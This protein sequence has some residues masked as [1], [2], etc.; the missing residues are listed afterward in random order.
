MERQVLEK[1]KLTPIPLI[2][3]T[4]ECVIKL[5]G[6]SWQRFKQLDACLDGIKFLRLT[7]VTGLLE[8]M[9][10]SSKHERLK[11]TIGY[12]LE[13]Y[14]RENGIRFYGCGGFTLMKEGESSGEPDESYCIGKDKDIPDIVIEVIITSGSIK[15]LD[16]YKSKNVPEVWFW[17]SEQLRIFHLKGN[18]YQEIPRSKFLPELDLDILLRYTQYQDQYDAV[19]DFVKAIQKNAPD[20]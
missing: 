12:L 4:G 5:S 17:K 9:T 15:K 10:I 13:A 2:E 14:M 1:L 3:N 8:I 19:Q 20:Y 11:T 16:I 6:I 18:D 7:Y